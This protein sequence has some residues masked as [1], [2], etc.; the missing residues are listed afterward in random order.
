MKT[1][2]LKNIKTLSELN[3][4]VITI[5]KITSNSEFDLASLILRL[6]TSYPDGRLETKP[7]Q[8]YDP[9]LLYTKS[10]EINIDFKIVDCS[11]STLEI[12]NPK[13]TTFEIHYE[14]FADKIQR[15]KE[16]GFRLYK[17]MK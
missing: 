9:N 8:T 3:D 13:A 15:I 12:V 5:K 14:A 1:F 7:V 16:G 11:I 6:H 2:K 10:P 17:V 4:D